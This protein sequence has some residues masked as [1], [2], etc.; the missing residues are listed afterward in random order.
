MCS[1]YRAGA[2]TDRRI[3]LEDQSKS[4]K[5]SSPTK[6]LYVAYG[7]P[8]ESGNGVSLWPSWSSDLDVSVFESGH[9]VMEENPQAVLDTFLPFF[10]N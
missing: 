3:D 7:F 6:A 8:A 2:T 5:N 4:R 9:L 10:A 1:D